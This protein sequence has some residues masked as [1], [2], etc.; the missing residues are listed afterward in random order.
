MKRLIL[1]FALWWIYCEVLPQQVTGKVSDSKTGEGLPGVLIKVENNELATVTDVEGNF[2]FQLEEGNYVI[3]ASLLGYTLQTKA[4]SVPISAPLLFE[5]KEEGLDLTEVEVV[6]TGYQELPRER[7]TGS[8][9]LVDEELVNRRVSTSLLDRLED[10]TSGLIFNRAGSSSDPISIRGRSTLFASAQPLIIVDNFPYDGPVENINP[11]DVASVTVLKDAAAASI[12][13]AKAGNGVIVI[14]TKRGRT[15]QPMR[16]TLNS[17]I[18]IIEADDPFYQPIISGSDFLYTEELLFDRGFYNNLFNHNN[19]TA[20]SP[21]VEDLFAHRNGLIGDAELAARRSGY[22]LHDVRN[23]ISRYYL[24]N[25]INQQYALNVSGGSDRHHYLYSVGYDNNRAGVI[26]NGSDRFTINAQNTWKF[27]SDKLKV[28]LG[29][30]MAKSLDDSGNELPQGFVYERLADDNGLPLPITRTYS[31][32]YLSSVEGIGLMD[33][34]YRPLEEINMIRNRLQSNDIRLNLGVGYKLLEGLQAEALY[35]YWENRGDRQVHYPEGSYFVRNLFNLY[36]YFQPDGTLGHHMPQ[37]GIYDFTHSNSL[38]HSLRGQ[39]RYGRQFGKHRLDLLSG[40]E[41]KMMDVHSDGGRFYGYDDALGTSQPVDYLTRFR[42]F[43]NN[44][45]SNIPYRGVHSGLY[46][47]F[48]SGYVNGGYTYDNRYSFTFSA[49]RDASN[50]FGV[51][52]NQRAVPLWSVGGAWT[53]SEERFYR[54]GGLPYMKLRM[55]YGYNGNID[56][57]L[58]SFTTAVYRPASTNNSLTGFALPYAQIQ[59]PPNPELRWERIGIF[60]TG[61][62][63]ESRG[64]KLRGTIEYYKKS[65]LDLIGDSPYPPSSGV[66]NFRGNYA[67]TTTDGVDVILGSDLRVGGFR[68]QPEFLYSHVHEVVTSYAN[69]AVAFNYVSVGGSGGILPREGFPLFSIYSYPWAGLD[70]DTGNPQVYFEGS[71]NSNFTL[72]RNQFSTEDLVFHGS[73]RPTHFGAFRNNIR[74]RDFSASFNI[75]YRFGYFYRRESVNYFPILRGEGGHSDF[76]HRWQHPGDEAFT[77]I[78][79]LP[80]VNNQNR[81]NMYLYSDQLVEQG[82]HIRLQ[83]VR[84]SYEFNK[85]RYGRMPFQRAELYTYANNL[86]ILWKASD[87][88]LDPDF[89]TMRP[90]RSIAAGIRI[91]F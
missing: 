25:R 58:S 49:R 81:D 60:N 67:N 29:V 5:L 32:R 70:P 44:G 43:H 45:L 2:I 73:M 75:S 42:F 66:I 51:E 57:N 22:T 53:L 85:S 9:A 56:R 39:L 19:K 65:G 84:L 24:Q 69:E 6:S 48:L 10:V 38:S 82:D 35:Q 12:W 8:F 23:D 17:N 15:N 80:S 30:Y 14:T 16:V 20:L 88:P 37:G 91:D 41:I 1:T 3:I 55:T 18:N 4:V 77:Q 74:W 63:F 34:R 79:S 11:N 83:D 62:D 46:E 61:M 28:D 52:A 50:L 40:Y 21:F 54:W 68:W 76:N 13:G 7:A 86:G 78:P 27:L 33:W 59:N 36:S 31:Q 64:G 26:G 89:R 71:P 90:L 47:R 87:D 72:I